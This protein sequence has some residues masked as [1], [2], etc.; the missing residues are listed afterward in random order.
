MYEEFGRA[1]HLASCLSGC[2]R[3]IAAVSCAGMSWTKASVTAIRAAWIILAAT[4]PSACFSDTRFAGASERQRPA[5]L[6][7]SAVRSPDA[8]ATSRRSHETHANSDIAEAEFDGFR[9]ALLANEIYVDTAMTNRDRANTQA[10]YDR[11]IARLTTFY[12]ELRAP[13]ARTFFC[14]SDPCR[15]YFTGPDMRAS[16][17]SPG[18]RVSGARYVA[19]TR[20][21]IINFIDR[22][23]E[24]TTAHEISHIEFEFRIAP[25]RAPEWF[26]EGLASYLGPSSNCSNQSLDAVEDLRTLDDRRAWLAQT[27]ER[28]RSHAAY[29]QALREFTAWFNVNGKSKLMR[30]FDALK[31][32]ETFDSA[33]GPLTLPPTVQ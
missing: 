19:R 31:R 10:I 28:S 26:N 15:L 3:S 1:I 9:M 12:G 27:N 33:Y 21:I 7:A 24:D 25:A 11:A 22:R 5:H 20:T 14:A 32:G 18:G 29:C 8:T 4:T 30:L 16:N 6:A 17:L 13:R 2:G 23:A